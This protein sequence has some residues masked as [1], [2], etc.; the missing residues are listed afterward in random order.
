MGNNLLCECSPE[1][2]LEVTVGHKM[3]INYE[4]G[5]RKERTDCIKMH[6]LL[7]GDL[8]VYGE[9]KTA[10]KVLLPFLSTTSQEEGRQYIVTPPDNNHPAKK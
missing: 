8:P 10:G 7:K 5:I 6:K 3:K 1:K 9:L 2:H 4:Q